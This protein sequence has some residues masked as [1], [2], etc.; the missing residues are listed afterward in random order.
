MRFWGPHLVPV[1]LLTAPTTARRIHDACSTTKAARVE[2]HSERQP[3]F[4]GLIYA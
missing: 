2:T 1:P 3:T 4:D